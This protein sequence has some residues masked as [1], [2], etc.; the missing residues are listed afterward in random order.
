MSF[1][2]ILILFIIIVFDL[3]YHFLY[4]RKSKNPFQKYQKQFIV[5]VQKI[6]DHEL[7]SF[8]RNLEIIEKPN[9]PDTN[10]I[11]IENELRW[12]KINLIICC[13]VDM[14]GSTMLS[15]SLAE[16]DKIAKAYIA[17]LNQL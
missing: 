12:Y 10:E 16:D 1:E 15:A 3:V 5:V 4:F 2:A 7:D 13:F 11:P 6:I 17:I 9:I 14:K 8:G